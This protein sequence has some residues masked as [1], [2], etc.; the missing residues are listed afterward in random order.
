M[1]ERR[2]WPRKEVAWSVA[3]TIDGGPTIN[4]KAVDASRYGLRLAVQDPADLSGIA[5]GTRCQV[6]VRLS[7][8]EAR[9]LRICEVVYLGQQG[10]GLLFSVPLPTALVPAGSAEIEG[11]GSPK[12]K[13]RT[14][15]L[16]SMLRSVALAPLQH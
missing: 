10:V 3:M 9:F 16:M 4:A 13:S 1:P 12:P 5:H 2:R 15:S 11:Q 8:G 6:E 14:T 7:G